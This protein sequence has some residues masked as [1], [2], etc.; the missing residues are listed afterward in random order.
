MPVPKT[1]A[2]AAGVI[3][4]PW[5]GTISE[6]ARTPAAVGAKTALT[7]Q[8]WP[9]LRVLPTQPSLRTENWSALGLPKTAL[10]SGPIARVPVLV[11]VKP[12]GRALRPDLHRAEVLRVRRQGRGL[13]E[14]SRR[15]SR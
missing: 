13:L 3:P 7:T 11:K 14:R 2:V 1:E 9:V 5:K 12:T 15:G 8:V 4:A 6:A 10:P